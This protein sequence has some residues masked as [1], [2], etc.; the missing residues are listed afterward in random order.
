MAQNVATT[1]TANP[2]PLKR[3]MDDLQWHLSE[4]P[5]WRSSLDIS[6]MEFI[7]SLAAIR[8]PA[9]YVT[10]IGIMSKQATNSS[11]VFI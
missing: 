1:A 6:P 9:I 2:L 8:H 7:L 3:P 10:N 11:H 5:L 4:K